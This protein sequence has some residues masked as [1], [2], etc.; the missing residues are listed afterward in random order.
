MAQLLAFE[1]AARSGSFK[2]AA[3]RLHRTPSTISHD[4]A[5]LERFLGVRLFER[6]PRHVVLTDAGRV[7]ADRLSALLD[8]LTEATAAVRAR[9]RPAAVRISTN[10]LTAAEIVTPLIPDFEAA[11]PGITLHLSV[12]EVLENPGQRD[13]DFAIRYGREMPDGLI[14]DR[15]CES[16]AVPVAAP[17]LDWSSA[18]RIDYALGTSTA[19]ALWKQRGFAM[20][21]HPERE[22]RFSQFA[23][24]MGAA[25]QG[26][27]I[28]LG[29]LPLLSP[30]IRAGR[31]T[32]LPGSDALPA[33]PIHLLSRRLA[34]DETIWHAIRAWWL[35]ALRA[36]LHE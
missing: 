11:F 23:A 18:P 22:R 2:A 15:I 35:A 14:C 1:A 31:L 8:A 34:E 29:I 16:R 24:A 7:Y 20:P 28:A 27:G 13:V 9:S 3:E 21:G 30:L 26:M 4:I 25:E 33:D 19:W 6:R 36:A 17:G 5:A 12:T 32:V 10:P